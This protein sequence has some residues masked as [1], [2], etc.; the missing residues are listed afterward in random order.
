M[1]LGKIFGFKRDEVTGEW[2]SI[3]D[4]ELH[5]LYCTPNIVQEMKKGKIGGD[6]STCGGR[7]RCI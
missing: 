3:Y 1:V 7:E 6:R 5:D 4:E 2:R